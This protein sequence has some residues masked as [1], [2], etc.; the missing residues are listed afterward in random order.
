MT[1]GADS[2]TVTCPVSHVSTVPPHIRLDRSRPV[3]VGAP[4]NLRRCL[5]IASLIFASVPA[6]KD[7][8]SPPAQPPPPPPPPPTPRV[9]AG[10]TISGSVF[11]SGG[12][13][14][15]FVSPSGA[16][17]AVFFEATTGGGTI[18]VKDSTTGFQL[19]AVSDLAGGPGL[20]TQVTTNFSRTGI[21]RLEVIGGFAIRIPRAS[22]SSFTQSTGR[23]SHAGLASRSATQ[24][25]VSRSTRLRMS[26][27][28]FWMGMSD[29]ISPAG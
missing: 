9:L 18:I 4:T 17:Y 26:M 12:V 7:P 28:S 22:V 10:D 29:S 8:S 2:L 23:R 11:A 19:A 6:C 1:F 13:T 15:S 25:A 14:Y 24:S 20:A 21:L 5:L 3:P 16:E 27:I